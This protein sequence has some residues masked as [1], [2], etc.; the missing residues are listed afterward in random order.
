M[1]NE[2]SRQWFDSFLATIPGD[3][4][5]FEVSSITGLLPLPEYRK[6]L[7]AAAGRVATPVR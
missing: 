3:W 2:Y 1:A 4:T 6:L 5:D 7:E